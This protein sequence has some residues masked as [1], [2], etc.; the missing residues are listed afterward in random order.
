MS[1]I[2]VGLDLGTANDYSA[3]VA[4]ERVFKL[5]AYV[6]LNQWHRSP[7]QYQEHLLEERHVRHLRRW[8][9]GTTYPSVVEDV[10]AMMRSP[11]L[12]EAVLVIDATGVGRAILH[13]FHE[14]HEEEPI[15]VFP[16]IGIQATGG[17]KSH[18]WNV[19]KRDLMAAIQANLQ[20]GKLKIA[21]NLPL[22][23]S[24]EKELTNFHLKITNSGRD[25]FEYKR[26]ETSDG[27][28][29]LASALSLALY[30]DNTSGRP[31]II[32]DPSTL[33]GK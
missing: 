31:E 27:H 18:G 25:S 1:S 11:A 4:V 7:G 19:T 14:A 15:G 2:T 22:G 9:L 21:D 26:S 30:V 5:P 29:D 16:P 12:R 8:E 28:G 24:L 3:L 13:M 20:L 32:E 23:E 33:I 10:A 17:D 6:S